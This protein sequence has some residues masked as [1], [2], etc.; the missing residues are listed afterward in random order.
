MCLTL[1]LRR[2]FRQEAGADTQIVRLNVLRTI[3][4]RRGGQ[5]A[6]E[7]FDDLGVDFILQ[8]ENIF[9]R[10]VKPVGPQVLA[11]KRVEQLRIDADTPHRASGAPRG[12]SGRRV[13]GR[14]AVRRPACPCKRRRNCAR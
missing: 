4:L 2:L 9:H 14:P 3:A 13:P 6:N 10:P 1:S 11:A 7:G 12:R 5:A 8:L